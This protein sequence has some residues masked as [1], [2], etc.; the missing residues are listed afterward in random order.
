MFKENYIIK[1]Q[2]VCE[3]GLHIGGANDTIEIGVVDQIVMRD[4]VLNI[5][6][7]PGSSLKGKMRSL[8]EINNR[9]SSSN[10]IKSGGKPCNCGICEVC[11]IFGN[12]SDDSAGKQKWPTRI[13]VRDSFPT[14]E[15]IKLW[16]SHE[17][18]FSGAEIKHENTLNR[19]TSE[20]KP[21]SIERVPKGSKF[22]FEIIF[23]VYEE[24][25]NNIKNV[26]NAMSLAEDNY[27]GG[28]GSR[29]Y[30]KIRFD[31]ISLYR[32]SQNDYKEMKDKEPVAEGSI[33]EIIDKLN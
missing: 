6:F 13:I 5:P 17:E 9:E 3:T 29:G 20:A 32:R 12:S 8:M 19:I 28:S 22:D 15:T 25:E 21:R 14:S 23:S 24:D 30:G 1:G 26:F 33:I 2:I 10:L 31:N 4:S 16:E 11:E 7:I 27:L 18:V